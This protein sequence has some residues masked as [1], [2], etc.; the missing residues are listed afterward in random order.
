MLP[1]IAPQDRTPSFFARCIRSAIRTETGIPIDILSAVA[2]VLETQR[3]DFYVLEAAF[4]DL[5]DIRRAGTSLLL[6]PRNRGG[7]FWPAARSTTE[8]ATFLKQCCK[9]NPKAW[10]AALPEDFA[11][12]VLIDA[13]TLKPGEISSDRVNQI[14]R[15]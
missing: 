5:F 2:S 14:E 9:S 1:A 13:E 3:P 12:F 10:Y 6:R 8:L 7:S 15:K 4:R 11:S